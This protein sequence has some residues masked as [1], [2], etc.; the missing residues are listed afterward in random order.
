MTPMKNT[1]YLELVVADFAREL[2]E[3]LNSAGVSYMNFEVSAA[4]R[5]GDGDLLITYRVSDSQYGGNA[6]NGGQP[7]PA[8]EELLRRRGWTS[9]HQPLCLP[10]GE[11]AAPSDD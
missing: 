9:L 5:T 8:V 4:G 2:R 10:R 6:V 7:Q 11:P 3:L 1:A